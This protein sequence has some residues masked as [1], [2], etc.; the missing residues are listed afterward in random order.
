MATHIVTFLAYFPKITI[1]LSNHQPVCLCA[2]LITSDSYS[3]NNFKMIELQSF[4][5]DTVP[6]Q[7]SLAYQWV[8]FV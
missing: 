7:F 5:L 2:P 6:T 8:G 4:E 3:F 1:G